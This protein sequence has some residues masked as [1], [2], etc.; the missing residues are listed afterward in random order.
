MING[1]NFFSD[2]TV[3]NKEVEAIEDGYSVKG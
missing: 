2:M 3:L 1:E